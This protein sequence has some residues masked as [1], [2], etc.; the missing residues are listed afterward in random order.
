[1]SLS[2]QSAKP[3][4]RIKTTNVLG[5]LS[6]ANDSATDSTRLSAGSTYTVGANNFDAAHQQ[7]P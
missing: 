7:A 1:M 2:S 5:K 6:A 4:R 3:D